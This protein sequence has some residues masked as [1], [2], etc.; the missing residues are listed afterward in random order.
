VIAIAPLKQRV[1]S[2]PG[3]VLLI[4]EGGYLSGTAVTRRL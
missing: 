2:K 3:S 4:Q 1:G